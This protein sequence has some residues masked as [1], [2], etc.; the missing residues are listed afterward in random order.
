M[1]SVVVG[2]EH[3]AASIVVDRGLWQHIEEYTIL[4]SL[5]VVCQS[6]RAGV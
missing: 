2:G 5:Y 6:D 3:M 1:L 4:I